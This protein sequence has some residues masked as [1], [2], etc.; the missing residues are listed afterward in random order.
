M[1]VPLFQSPEQWVQVPPLP[2][3]RAALQQVLVPL[4]SIP[5]QKQPLALPLP[6]PLLLMRP[7][8]LAWLHPNLHW[9][10][11]PALWQLLLLHAPLQPQTPAVSP[12]PLAWLRPDL[13]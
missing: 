11:T 3:L 2:P 6:P 10:H 8:P 7:A 9:P 13:H 4:L 5:Q 12:A 1:Q